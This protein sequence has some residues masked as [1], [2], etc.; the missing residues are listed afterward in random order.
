MSR[1]LV[2]YLRVQD[3]QIF[4]AA[5]G[6]VYH[7]GSFGRLWDSTQW[8]SIT[9]HSVPL[10]RVGAQPRDLNGAPIFGG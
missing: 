9:W 8:R 10:L 4:L 7:L 6:F 1:M 2:W 5:L 3:R